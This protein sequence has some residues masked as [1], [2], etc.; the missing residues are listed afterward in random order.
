MITMKMK[1]ILALILCCL[2]LWPATGLGEAA[3]SYLY[4]F[5]PGE[6]LSGDGME[7]IRQFLGAVRLVV[8]TQKKEEGTS[9]A[10]VRLMSDGEEAFSLQA[11]NGADGAYSISCSLTGDN[12]LV[13]GKNQMEGFLKTLVQMLA[14]LN[15]LN[16]ESRVKLDGL[17]Q[18]A[19]ELIEN[20]M[21]E[22][23]EGGPE[24]GINLKPYLKVIENLSSEAEIRTLDGKDP[25][26][27]GATMV[28][29]YL[30]REKDLNELV[31]TALSKLDSIPV[32][33]NELSSGR[34]HIGEQVI[35]EDFIRELFASMKGETS[36]DLYQNADGKIMKLALHTPETPGL[37]TD[38]EFAKARGVEIIIDRTP[39]LFGSTT[40]VTTVK[41]IGLQGALMTV[42]L[43]KR[44]GGEL[45]IAEAKN[46]HEVGEMDSGELW[47]V[48][49]GLGLTIAKNAMNM[50]LVL[51]RVVFDMV[52]NKLLHKQ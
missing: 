27:P 40:T 45:Q 4:T 1:K 6:I 9:V 44:V 18:Q 35:T 19:T 29:S 11:V 51:P 5:T 8:D 48:F 43:D 24:N 21:A 39:D 14:D 31:E 42:Q 36:L 32:L 25:E 49:H 37:I 50:I 2:L 15:V 46:V 26:C 10:Q 38:P 34:L 28:S 3:K 47:E 41:L 22:V 52:A 20:S 23:T 12:T 13:C 30:L 16:E 17:A 33:S 7:N